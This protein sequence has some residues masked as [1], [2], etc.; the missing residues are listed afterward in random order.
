MDVLTF[1]T[2]IIVDN[3]FNVL[4]VPSYF[5]FYN[6]NKVVKNPTP[7]PES[8]LDSA[9]TL[10]GTFESVDYRESSTKLVCLYGNTGSSKLSME[11]NGSYRFKSDAPD[12]R[13]P[14]SGFVDDI[15]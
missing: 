10:F 11:D 6:V 3:G 2:T 1:V 4:N 15:N 13:K 9:N 14:D 7:K 8:S 12:L 5:N